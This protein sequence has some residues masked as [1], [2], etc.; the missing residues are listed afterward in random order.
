MAIAAKSAWLVLAPA[1]ISATRTDIDWWRSEAGKVTEYRDEKSLTCALVLN[2]DH[3]EFQFMWNETLPP[4]AIV[5]RPDW[6]LPVNH[7]STASLRIGDTW[8]TTAEGSR[9]LPA[10][11]EPHGLMF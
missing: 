6:T 10:V 4:Y 9:D 8:L 1:L 3:G 2:A 7:M 11:T 5:Q